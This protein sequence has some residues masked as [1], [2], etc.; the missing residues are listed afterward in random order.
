MTLTDPVFVSLGISLAIQA[1]FFAFAYGFRTDKVTDFS[2][3][4]SFITIAWY[5]FL[6]TGDSTTG[7]RLVLTLMI[8][9]WGI[10]LSSFLLVRVIK[11]GRDKR[12][13]DKRDSFLAFGKFWLLQGLVVWLVMLPAVYILASGNVPELGMVALSGLYMWAT[14]LCI[15]TLADFQL[16]RFR[17]LKSKTSKKHPWIDEGLWHYSRHPNYFGE[18]LLWWGVFVYGLSVYQ[19]WGWLTVIGPLTITLLLLFG[20]G[21][22][23]LEKANNRRWGSDKAYQTYKK[24]TSVLVPLPKRKKMRIRQTL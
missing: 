10:R 2:Y 16:Y 24:S 9:L 14:G 23:I 1:F 18:I 8:T 4:L 17:F 22:P 3:G 6:R 12:F 11:T 7:S 19:G 21:I 20:S 13:D 5:W 15:E